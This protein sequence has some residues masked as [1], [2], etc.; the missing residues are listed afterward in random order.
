[1][2]KLV[3]V[4]LALAIFVSG[5]YAFEPAIIGGFRDGLAIGI[6]GKTPL[7]RNTALRLGVEA[8]SGNAPLIAFIGGKFYLGRAGRMPLSL[9]LSGVLYAGNKASEFGFGLSVVF[10]RVFNVTPMFL[11]AGVDIVGSAKAQIQ[12]GY[13]IY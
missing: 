9:G 5:A 6:M 8:T 2:K 12:L 7:A 3:L 1:M 11:E 13:R 10:D 4:S